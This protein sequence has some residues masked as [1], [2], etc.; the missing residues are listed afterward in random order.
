MKRPI[1]RDPA[2]D[3]FAYEAVEAGPEW[4]L[5]NDG[6]PCDCCRCR[7]CKAPAAAVLYRKA[8]YR[9]GVRSIP[10]RYCSEHMY[11]RWIEGGKVMQWRLVPVAAGSPS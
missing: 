3:G 7:R 2:P 8:R 6:K 1:H 4:T 9:S 11:G 10:W 5:N